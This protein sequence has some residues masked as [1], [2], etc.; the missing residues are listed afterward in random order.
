MDAFS[1]YINPG[2]DTPHA[3]GFGAR[4]TSPPIAAHLPLACTH[5]RVTNAHHT[6]GGAPAPGGR[7][8]CRL[9][10]QHG[11]SALPPIPPA[12][13]ASRRRDPSP[14]GQGLD[15]RAVPSSRGACPEQKT[16]WAALCRAGAPPDPDAPCRPC[17]QRTPL[18]QVGSPPGQRRC[19]L[20]ASTAGSWGVAPIPARPAPTPPS[21]IPRLFSHSNHRP[22][23]I[24]AHPHPPSL[25]SR[26]P[27]L[28]CPLPPPPPLPPHTPPCHSPP[29]L[30]CVVWTPA[31][32]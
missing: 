2:S 8:A 29:S 4:S 7:L 26:T 32:Q 6:L 27:P 31:V 19:H 21:R 22:H 14:H 1:K 16:K 9:V 25:P 20:Q 12:T 23:P 18:H 17:R 3:S 24:L 10:L 15:G 13:G 28:F 11:G 5:P 30:T